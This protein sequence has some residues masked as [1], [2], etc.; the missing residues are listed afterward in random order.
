MLLFASR[1]RSIDHMQYQISLHYL[2]QSGAE[3]RYQLMREFS[4]ESHRIGN[5]NWKIAAQLDT[6][7][8]GIEC[9]KQPARHQGFFFGKCAEERR[10]SSIG[11]P[12]QRHQRQPVAAPAFPMEL[13]VFSDVLD[14]SF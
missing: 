9:R 4:D 11:I 1:I 7:D 2:F 6:T 14:L 10:F 3:R 8:Q 13:A 12:D 5:Q